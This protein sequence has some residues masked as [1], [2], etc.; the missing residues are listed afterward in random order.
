MKDFTD[1]ILRKFPYDEK[2][3][4]YVKPNTPAGKLNRAL[5]SNS[6]IQPAEIIAFH[7]SKIEKIL[8]K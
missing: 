1:V 7:K 3:E 8:Q 4:F 6:K 2:L 5:A